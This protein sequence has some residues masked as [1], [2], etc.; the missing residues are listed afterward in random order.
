MS[1]EIQPNSF[2]WPGVLVRLRF[3]TV[4]RKHSWLRSQEPSY[5]YWVFEHA[6]GIVLTFVQ[7]GS[8][9]LDA[10]VHFENGKMGWVFGEHVAEVA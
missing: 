5:S 4:L 7:F 8:D 6:L 9:E 10:L 2:V 3:A 1:I